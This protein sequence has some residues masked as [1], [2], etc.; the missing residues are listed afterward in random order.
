[1]P[2]PSSGIISY[3]DLGVSSLGN[4]YAGFQTSVINMDARTRGG[5]WIP[6]IS[7]GGNQNVPTSASNMGLGSYYSVWGYRR[8]SFNIGISFGYYS[9]DGKN[10]YYATGYQAQIGTGP[11][12]SPYNSRSGAFGS[13]SANT[14]LTP[15]GTMTITGFYY[16]SGQ[17][18]NTLLLNC[19][20]GAPPDNDLTVIAFYSGYNGVLYAR[21]TPYR[22]AYSY[23][24]LWGSNAGGAMLPT[25]GTYSCYVNYYG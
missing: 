4:N 22:T 16:D 12:Q 3:Y 10:T 25:S 6:N 9:P 15:N 13:I 20:T 1:M 17:Y 5:Y 19:N 14:F 7:A 11:A 24:R 21:T 18:L 2:T 8:L 23:T